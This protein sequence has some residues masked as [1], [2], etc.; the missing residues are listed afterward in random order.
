MLSKILPPDDTRPVH[1][2]T[3]KLV[4]EP[5]SPGKPEPAPGA[6]P[7]AEVLSRME[8]EFQRRV[9]DAHAAGV[10]EGEAAARSRVSAEL[11]PVL[12]RLARSIDEVAGLRGRLRREAEGD[13]IRLALSIARRILHRELAVDPEAMHGLILAALEKIQS[14]EVLRVRIHPDFAPLLGECLKRLSGQKPVEIVPDA[15][16]DR[17]LLVLETSRGN[18]DASIESQLREIERG[19]TDRLR[20]SE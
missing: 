5:L 7:D 14:Q 3:W 6:A 9:S 20:R 1:P 12:E 16:R 19:L 4:G 15:S 8:R 18:L 17:G 10:R 13:L 2:V 11:Q